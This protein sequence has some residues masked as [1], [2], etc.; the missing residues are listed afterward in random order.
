MLSLHTASQPPRQGGHQTNLSNLPPLSKVH[1]Q[2][3][4]NYVNLGI[5][6]PSASHL[7]Q[8]LDHDGNVPKNSKA[9]SI[10]KASHPK[11]RTE[12]GS[13]S[14]VTHPPNGFHVESYPPI[15]AQDPHQPLVEVSSTT[16]EIRSGR[17]R[18]S[19]ALSQYHQSMGNNA[20]A[21][22]RRSRSKIFREQGDSPETTVC[23]L[24]SLSM[25]QCRNP[26]VYASYVHVALSS[27]PA[28]QP[29]CLALDIS[30]ASEPPQLKT[31]RKL[32]NR[33][34]T[35]PLHLLSY[36]HVQAQSRRFGSVAQGQPLQPSGKTRRRQR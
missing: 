18:R 15:S 8:G 19:S 22:I 16:A 9:L 25:S 31:D 21:M 28:V 11:P 20:S 2:D 12:Q 13:S 29:P 4:T 34:L 36:L 7:N 1:P 33:S 35:R 30:S 26:S 23:A 27:K 17:S 32:S 24:T 6:Q 5:N 14:R 10:Q 3:P